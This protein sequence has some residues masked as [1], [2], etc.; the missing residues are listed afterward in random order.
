MYLFKVHLI[1]EHV[2]S[3]EVDLMSMA[4]NVLSTLLNS[5]EL[6]HK[7]REAVISFDYIDEEIFV[8]QKSAFT[9]LFVC[10]WVASK[11][12]DHS[13][14][15]DERLRFLLLEKDVKNSLNLRPTQLSLTQSQQG[16]SKF[17]RRKMSIMIMIK[18]SQVIL[19]GL[20]VQ[21]FVKRLDNEL[22]T[23]VSPIKSGHLLWWTLR[24]LGFEGLINLETE[25]Q[26][27]LL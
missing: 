20:S 4:W 1:C 12:V 6:L 7:A 14:N 22:Q 18:F 24:I 10:A 21:F 2:Q 3:S 25:R 27:V 16:L 15:W 5:R 23:L 11:E 19:I 17:W 26:N 9:Y 13:F 8:D